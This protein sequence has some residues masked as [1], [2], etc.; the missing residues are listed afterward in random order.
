MIC[1]VV[2]TRPEIIKMS[3]V[4]KAL[5][6]EKME[7]FIINTGQHYSPEMNR[8]FFGELKVPTPL[9]DF[10][11]GSGSHAQTTAR[12]MINIETILIEEKPDI[13]LVQGDTNSVLAGALVASKLNIKIGHV[14]A[15]LRSY[16]R[17]PEE[18]N[19]IIVDHVSDMLFAPTTLSGDTLITEGIP[20]T[21]VFITGNTIVDAVMQNIE[22]VKKSTV[23]E[24]LH[25]L[26]GGYFLATVH[27][28]ENVDNKDTFSSILK[29]FNEIYVEYGLPIVF[30]LHPRSKKRID[31]FG[32]KCESGIHLVDPVGFIDFLRLVQCARMALTDSGGVQEE[33]CILK[34]PCVTLRDN[35]ERPETVDIGA[36][37][38]AGTTTKDIV[39]RVRNMSRHFGGHHWDNAVLG[40]GD[41]GI[42]I[43]KHLKRVMI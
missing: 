1:I 34:T 36:N 35:T 25:I 26:N 17:M 18:T 9:Y 31:E 30:P 14:E 24:R 41:A 12:A 37:I 4:V 10:S 20:S 43:V 21:K 32:L 38:L 6:E 27:R 19:R 11:I 13:V 23:L 8:Y 16:H 2:G 15:G 42:K 5:E 40:H 7:Y 28:E 3:S 29:A 39:G 33:A 22:A